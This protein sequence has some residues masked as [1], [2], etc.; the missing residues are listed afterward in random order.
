M[1]N[2][3]SIQTKQTKKLIL[4]LKKANMQQEEEKDQ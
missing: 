4:I 2:L 1:W 3:T